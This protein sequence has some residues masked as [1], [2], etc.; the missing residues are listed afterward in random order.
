[1]KTI[2][3]MSR[4]ELKEFKLELAKKINSYTPSRGS[5]KSHYINSLYEGLYMVEERLKKGSD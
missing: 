2:I 4:Q 3:E 1:M 5:G